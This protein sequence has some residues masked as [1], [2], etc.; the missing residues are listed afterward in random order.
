MFMD[1]FISFQRAFS[2]DRSLGAAEEKVSRAD[3]GDIIH[4]ILLYHYNHTTACPKD[5]QT[6]G[7]HP[8]RFGNR[9]TDLKKPGNSDTIGYKRASRRGK[10]CRRRK[11]DLG[12]HAVSQKGGEETRR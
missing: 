3:P 1:V 7:V 10:G 11:G 4:R 12:H 8:T 5:V 9:A 2:F 6:K